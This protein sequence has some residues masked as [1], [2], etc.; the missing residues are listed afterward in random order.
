MADSN[1]FK[2]ENG[3]RQY[4]EES[5]EKLHDQGICYICR[6]KRKGYHVE[7]LRVVPG[8]TITMGGWRFFHICKICNFKDTWQVLLIGPI[9]MGLSSYFWFGRNLTDPDHKLLVGLLFLAGL[10]TLVIS[11]LDL[12]SNAKA[13]AFSHYKKNPVDPPLK[14]GYVLTNS[15][16]KV[17][18]I[19]PDKYDLEEL[20]KDLNST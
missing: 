14:I 2:P 13:A 8:T 16:R 18:D 17:T 3:N 5:I 20:N 19:F 11:F 1:H 9:L 4:A 6:K 12:P 7:F 15:D 10:I